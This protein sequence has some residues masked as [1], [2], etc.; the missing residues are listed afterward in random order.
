VSDLAPYRLSRLELAS[1]LVF[2]DDTP[3]PELPEPQP[4]STPVQV[5]EQAVLAA[6]QRPPCLVSFSGGRDSSGIL[7][8]ATSLARR[9]GLPPP[10]PATH[11][12]PDA[13][14]SDETEWQERVIRHL[15]L[16][17]WM[18]RE[19]TDEFDC[20]GPVATRMLRRHGVLWPCNT[21]F[22][23]PL[24][25]AAAGG[26]L[27]TGIG[28]DE[29]FMT[30]ARSVYLGVLRGAR[31]PA[32]RDLLRIGYA[33]APESLR[34]FVIGRRFPPVAWWLKP[35]ALA[36]VRSRLARE[37][38]REPLGWSRRFRWIHGFH[39]LKVGLRSL[40]VVAHDHDVLVAHPFTQPEFLGALAR[41]RRSDRF[42]SRSD[43]MRTYFVGVLPAELH[44]RS[45]KARFDGAFWTRHS[46]ELVADWDGDGVDHELV[47]VDVLREVWRSEAPDARSFTVLQGVWLARNGRSA[48]ESGAE[49]LQQE[50]DRVV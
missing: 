10:I 49:A 18:R 19:F 46:K 4:G 9:E 37:T 2:G 40:E 36:E 17:D 29:A 13:E 20:V 39:Y 1:G 27:L 42:Q 48:E 35:A 25:E 31:R 22:H 41:L 15:G 8:L 30:P 45:T 34:E 14:G 23:I 7:A 12:F 16:D 21:H 38:A 47:D 44:G 11:R 33:L 43:G 32:P 28:G 5:L 26:S 50:L 24:F 3:P 6:L